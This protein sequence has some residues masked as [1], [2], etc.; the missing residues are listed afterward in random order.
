M[1]EP[2]FIQRVEPGASHR[3][4]V[5]V[6]VALDAIA[7]ECR[8]SLEPASQETPERLYERLYALS[9]LDQVQ[10]SMRRKYA[11]DNQLDRFEKLAPLLTEGNTVQYAEMARQWNITEGS[12]KPAVHRFRKVY[13]GLLRQKIAETVASPADVDDEIRFLLAALGNS[14]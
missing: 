5:G 12:V 3:S 14:S 1:C 10:A 9:L 8:Y 2:F 7:A 11:Q 6:P 4:V 13:R